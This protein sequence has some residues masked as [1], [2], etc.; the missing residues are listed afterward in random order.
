MDLLSNINLFSFQISTKRLLTKP[1]TR[2]FRKN[3]EIIKIH[4]NQD[5]AQNSLRKA[6][7]NTRK[8]VIHGVSASNMIGEDSIINKLIHESPN[9]S[10][11]EIYLLDNLKSRFL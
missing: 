11:I 8:L 4:T 3:S 2:F 9:L 6:I 10:K 5:K 7:N 1:L